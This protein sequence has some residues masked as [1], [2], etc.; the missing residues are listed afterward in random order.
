MMVPIAAVVMSLSAKSSM[1]ET[2]V[3]LGR[4]GQRSEHVLLFTLLMTS[5]AQVGD[6]EI[7]SS[8][9]L[10]TFSSFVKP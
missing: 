4:L 8:G 6:I 1:Q 7:F 2:R 5:E 3:E 10:D 9:I